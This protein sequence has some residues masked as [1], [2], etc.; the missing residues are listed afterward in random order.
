MSRT[1]HHHYR[2][3][4]DLIWLG[5]ARRIGW[6][7]ERSPEVYA[8][9]DG[10]RTLTLSDA[11]GFDPDDC[12]AQ[13]I[14]HEICHALVQGEGG[15][16]EPDWGL[17]NFDARD[18]VAEHGCHRLQAALAD[19]VGL[20]GL[21]AVTTEWRPYWDALPADPLA[22]GDDPAIALARSAWP[23]A[24]R[25]P[26]SAAIADGLAATA[27]IARAVA[28]FA[29]K[30]DLWGEAA[31]DE[32]PLGGALAPGEQT[33]GGCAWRFDGGP[34]RPVARC[35]RHRPAGDT[36]PRVRSTW[37]ACAM[38]E[39]P[40]TAGGCLDCGACCRHGFDL[41]QVGAREPVV[42]ARPDLV[43]R[44]DFGL[45]IPRP[46]GRCLA[47]GEAR[48][49]WPCAVYEQRPRSCRDFEVGGEACLEARRR[50]GLSR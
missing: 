24:T 19:T 36:A 10:E 23:A 25:G 32:H 14:L 38:W 50:V 28:P 4:L 6:R 15:Q 1:I 17:C 12:L 47:L 18:L 30:H 22:P 39:P 48:G 45:H 49:P 16:R 13:M 2:D 44:D 7:I 41:V 9:W 29:R 11:A 31:E 3:P 46:D 35:R 42:A 34:G 5:V 43:R 33:C 40:L 21:F 8:S 20:R 37:P 26:W 27:A